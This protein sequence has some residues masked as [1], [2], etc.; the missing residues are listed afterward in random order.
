MSKQ[1]PIMH[2]I[3]PHS[4]VPSSKPVNRETFPYKQLRLANQS[5]PAKFPCLNYLKQYLINKIWKVLMM[6]L[7]KKFLQKL[8]VKLLPAKTKNIRIS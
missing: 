1:D 6:M 8:L 3:L 4:P 7:S 2:Q 5:F